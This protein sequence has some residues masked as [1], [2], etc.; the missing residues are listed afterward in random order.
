MYALNVFVI[1]FAAEL[2]LFLLIQDILLCI[3]CGLILYDGTESCARVCVCRYYE[4]TAG[5][6][7]VLTLAD[8]I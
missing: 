6:V 2:P 7:H 3:L 4:N 8:P 1:T 5:Y